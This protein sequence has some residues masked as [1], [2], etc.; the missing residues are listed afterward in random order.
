[1]AN[2][3]WLRTI[4]GFLVAPISPGLLAVILVVPFRVGTDVFG[5]RELAE[6]AWIIKL[7]GI[8]GY[9]IAIVL[10]VPLYVFFR[11][12]G[13]NGLLIYIT[14]GALLGLIIYVIYVLLAEYS[15]NGLSG[16]AEKFSNT[17]LVYIPLGMICGA[18]AALSFWLIARPD[19][20]GLIIE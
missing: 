18:V 4:G 12:R 11:S 5:P 8:L 1:M 10:G 9:P 2:S 20:T 15:S 14:A 17:A 6:A 7:S 3:A 16:L 13:W 19:R